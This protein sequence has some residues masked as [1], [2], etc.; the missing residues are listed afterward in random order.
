M[1]LQIITAITIGF[2]RFD[3]VGVAKRE[4]GE[5]LRILASA[6]SKRSHAGAI[7]VCPNPGYRPG[8]AGQPRHAGGPMPAG[9]SQHGGGLP[10][11]CSRTPGWANA[12]S[13][14]SVRSRQL[15]G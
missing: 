4:L 14:P 8:R 5:M 9:L 10:R 6:L 2:G 1:R 15:A 7:A 13:E 3:V 11:T 12:T